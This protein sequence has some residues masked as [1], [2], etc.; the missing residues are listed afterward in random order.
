MSA[1]EFLLAFNYSYWCISPKYKVIQHF[2]TFSFWL[3]VSYWSC[4]GD[5]EPHKINFNTANTQKAHHYAKISF[6][7]QHTSKSVANY[8]LLVS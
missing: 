6:L 1:L 5:F 3:G 7:S 4:F 8:D 2:Q